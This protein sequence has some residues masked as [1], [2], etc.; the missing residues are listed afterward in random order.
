MYLRKAYQQA[1]SWASHHYK[2]GLRALSHVDRG[3]NSAFRLYHSL[4]PVLAS[5]ARK[6]LGDKADELHAKIAEAGRSYGQVRERVIQGDRMVRAIAST[7]DKE[8]RR[9]L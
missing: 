7:A 6:T 2:R 5:H 8:V 4:A 1:S 3:I 9:G